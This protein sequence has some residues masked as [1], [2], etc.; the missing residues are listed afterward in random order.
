MSIR[1]NSS[2]GCKQII[3][4]RKTPEEQ[5]KDFTTF[6][7]NSLKSLKTDVVDFSTKPKV[8]TENYE[9][10]EAKRIHPY[11][12]LR[13]VCTKGDFGDNNVTFTEEVPG[14]IVLTQIN[15]KKQK[16]GNFLITGFMNDPVS[17]IR[18]EIYGINQYGENPYKHV[19]GLDL[20]GDY[21]I[22]PDGTKID[23]SA[24][25]PKEREEVKKTLPKTLFEHTDNGINQVF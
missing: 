12:G 8:K 9:E 18:R 6:A 13:T 17:G 7:T 22:N 16:D 4:E 3:G 24:L 10:T 21:I 2:F 19:I 20:G 5:M 11:T 23:L 1:V 14:K 15:Q 25:S